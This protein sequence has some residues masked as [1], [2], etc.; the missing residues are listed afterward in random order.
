MHREEFHRSMERILA[1]YQKPKSEDEVRDF[2]AYMDTLFESVCSIDGFM[3]EQTTKELIKT[4]ARGQKPMPGQFWAVH[5]KLSTQKAEDAQKATSST[6]WREDKETC[7]RRAIEMAARL[8]KKGAEFALM[9][10]DAAPEKLKA[11]VH[12]DALQ[13]LIDKVSE[14]QR[15]AAPTAAV[16]S[17][18]P[19]NYEVEE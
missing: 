5:H 13:I 17:V 9:I 19:E 12:P 4:L 3:F 1:F 8:G 18:A 10:L 15:E 2:R 11:A 16:G 6:Q 7:D 14:P